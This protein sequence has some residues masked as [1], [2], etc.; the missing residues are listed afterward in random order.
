MDRRLLGVEDPNAVFSNKVFNL[1]AKTPSGKDTPKTNKQ[2]KPAVSTRSDNI[3]H[4]TLRFMQNDNGLAGEGGK[5][6]Q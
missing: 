6:G 1:K 4:S 2:T 5:A 3:Q